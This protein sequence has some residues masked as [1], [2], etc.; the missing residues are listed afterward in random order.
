MR[1]LQRFFVL[2]FM[3]IVVITTAMPMEGEEINSCSSDAWDL[4]Y[5]DEK[6]EGFRVPLF[7]TEDLLFQFNMGFSIPP[8]FDFLEPSEIEV[9]TLKP[10]ILGYS[11]GYRPGNELQVDLGW[12]F[13]PENE[14]EIETVKRLPPGNIYPGTYLHEAWNR[15]R[16]LP[17]I[18][19][20]DV[21]WTGEDSLVARLSMIYSR[22]SALDPSS[23]GYSSSYWRQELQDTMGLALGFRYHVNSI[24]TLQAD[25]I[26]DPS[27]YS[28]WTGDREQW[29]GRH[30]LH[31]GSGLSRS[32]FQMDLSYSYLLLYDQDEIY[33]D[34]PS[35]GLEDRGIL[36]VNIQY[37]F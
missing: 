37:R 3:L 12:F 31:F 1:N 20:G 11:M 8:S 30:I 2:L 18:L 23:Y 33:P 7:L 5:M 9:T 34:S 17:S 13:F 10:A 25:Y 28:M 21:S 32:N 35:S 19:Q 4:Y 24:M 15:R 22:W 16:G 26:Y 36:E 14:F 6:L 27:P 29:T